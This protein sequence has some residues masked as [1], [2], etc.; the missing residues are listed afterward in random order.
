MW[1]VSATRLLI[2]TTAKKVLDETVLVVALMCS[3][4][5]PKQKLLIRQLAQLALSQLWEMHAVGG[6]MCSTN[7]NL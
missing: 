1:C 4:S 7:R 5:S 3:T 6:R 2:V